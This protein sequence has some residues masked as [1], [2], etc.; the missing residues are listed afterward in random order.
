MDLE[1]LSRRNI[2]YHSKKTQQSNSIQLTGKFNFIA[3]IIC[4]LP[5][6][7]G[8][9]I[10]A[11][12]L[13]Y[14][15]F[16]KAE[17]GDSFL[18]LAWNSF[19]LAS[20]AALFTTA[21]ALLLAY[22][23]RLYSKNII[24]STAI[25]LST[26]GYALPGTIIAIGII[27][28]FANLDQLLIQLSAKLFNINHGLLLSGTIFT[29]LFAYTIRFLAIAFG[30]LDSSLQTI[31]PSIDHAAR[32]LG[33]KPLGVLSNIHLPIISSSIFTAMLIVFVDVLKE[34]PAT[35]ILRPFNFNTLSIRAYELAS[36]ERLIDAAPASLL[37]VLVGI[38]PVMILH[39]S[40]QHRST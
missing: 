10:P 33:K 28:P 30:S 39:H 15:S 34:L 37:I 2:K 24:I 16:F 9:F 20:L 29:L 17:L 11:F 40:I 18:S 32:S 25:S 27:V 23:K 6:C 13:L 35:L 7:F 36:D 26:L 4:F 1:K 8:F 19:F 14:W 31:S 5:F 3:V 38:I 22:C 12:L 21:I